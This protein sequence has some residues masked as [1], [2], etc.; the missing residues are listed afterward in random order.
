MRVAIPLITWLIVLTSLFSRS[1]AVSVNRFRALSEIGSSSASSSLYRSLVGSQHYSVHPR[2]RSRLVLY[3]KFSVDDETESKGSDKDAQVDSSS[4]EEGEEKQPI[5]NKEQPQ[6]SVKRD[7]F[8]DVFDFFLGLDWTLTDS[9]RKELEKEYYDQKVELAEQQAR[10]EKELEELDSYFINLLGEVKSDLEKGNTT[11][12]LEN[13]F[14]GFKSKLEDILESDKG[15][16]SVGQNERNLPTKEGHTSDQ[17]VERIS[18]ITRNKANTTERVE[19]R[20]SDLSAEIKRE[21]AVRRKE[22]QALQ[23]EQS[24]QSV[25]SIRTVDSS[26]EPDSSEGEDLEVLFEQKK[27]AIQFEKNKL[28]QKVPALYKESGSVV[29]KSPG[30]GVIGAVEEKEKEKEER[31]RVPLPF[32]IFVRPS[33]D[34]NTSIY[35]FD[36]ESAKY[37]QQTEGS[38]YSKNFKKDRGFEKKEEVDLDSDEVI[39]ARVTRLASELGIELDP[40]KNIEDLSYLSVEDAIVLGEALIDNLAEKTGEQ[41]GK[42]E[43]LEALHEEGLGKEEGKV[44]EQGRIPAQVLSLT[45]EETYLDENGKIRSVRTG[46]RV[47]TT[48]DSDSEEYRLA[49]EDWIRR[50]ELEIKKQEWHNEIDKVPAEEKDWSV[51][52]YGDPKSDQYKKVTEFFTY[53]YYSLPRIGPPNSQNPRHIAINTQIIENRRR[54]SRIKF[55]RIVAAQQTYDNVLDIVLDLNLKG[56]AFITQTLLQISRVKKFVRAYRVSIIRSFKHMQR[57]MNSNPLVKAWKKVNHWIGASAKPIV[58][59][60]AGLYLLQSTSCIPLY[61][62]VFSLCNAALSKIIKNIVKEPRPAQ[63]PKGRTYVHYFPVD[64]PM[65]SILTSPCHSLD[66][67]LVSWSQT[68]M[69]P[70]PNTICIFLTS[71]Q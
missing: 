69:F 31:G 1:V 63:S 8:D 49:V 30:E 62:I 40:T 44:K 15:G 52:L 45:P 51:Y 13:T 54:K 64:I 29:E 61:Y 47:W 25:K 18:D 58:S 27:R 37:S 48:Q 46:R 56:T 16:S 65:I 24:I 41:E 20:W 38:L 2:H 70:N 26:T 14:K 43:T 36:P 32:D 11:A 50:A 39:R 59:G 5:V 22:Q 71:V 35:G 33:I 55:E 6:A 10:K 60:S 3:D 42:A 9:E 53:T 7:F 67:L 28:L 21:V 4:S 23:K 17:G 68:Y 19:Q 12:A 57:K 66:V 34:S